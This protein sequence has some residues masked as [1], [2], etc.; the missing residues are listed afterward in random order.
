M[1]G[2]AKHH[3]PYATDE[4]RWEAILSRDIEADGVFLYSVRSTGIYCR[5]TC[6]GRDAK[7]ENVRFHANC[8]DAEAAGFRACKRCRPSDLPMKSIHAAAVE[9]ACRLIESADKLPPLA[10]LAAAVEM[11]QWHLHRIFKAELGLTP[12]EYGKAQRLGRVQ[13][14][15]AA[16]KPVTQAM[17]AAGYGSSSQ[18]YVESARTLGMAP[19]RYRAGG[20]GLVI[21]FAIGKCWLGDILVA[22]TEAGICAILLGDDPD[23]L[24]HDLEH[25]FSSAELRSGDKKFDRTVALVVGFLQ[26]PTQGLELPLDIRGTAFQQRVWTALQRVPPGK[27]TTYTEIARRLGKP[28]AVRAVAQACAANPL[29]VAIPCHRVVRRDGGLAGYR[30]GIERKRTLLEHEAHAATARRSS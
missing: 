21:T 22:A 1:S 7:R 16:S 15:L 27:T 17:Y 18:F 4:Q 14:E 6:G 11:S 30:W 10:E 20:A 19:A 3:P 12:R 26:A 23:E 29:A 13:Q 5:P 8:A 9:K 24:I 28:A 2:R 25:R